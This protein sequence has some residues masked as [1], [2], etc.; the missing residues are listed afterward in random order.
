MLVSYCGSISNLLMNNV[1]TAPVSF[2]N[3][4]ELLPF[5]CANLFSCIFYLSNASV[6]VQQRIDSS[7]QMIRVPLYTKSTTD[8]IFVL[9]SNLL[10]L[11]LL[12]CIA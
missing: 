9:Y 6:V 2:R 10:F 7:R 1:T 12:F 5:F 4:V 11:H 8:Y 3:D